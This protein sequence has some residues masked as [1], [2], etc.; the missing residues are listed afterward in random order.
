MDPDPG[1]PKTCGSGGSRSGFGSGSLTLLFSMF[2]G[3]FSP[4]GSGYGSS[5]PIEPGSTTLPKKL[6][7][8]STCESWE[9]LSAAA[10]G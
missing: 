7:V 10:P 2:V 4:P 9:A 1:G 6:R 3:H 5:F 8:A